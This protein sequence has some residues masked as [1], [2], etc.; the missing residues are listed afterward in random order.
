MKDA[1]RVVTEC[2][3]LQSRLGMLTPREES[4]ASG[5]IEFYE[6]KGYLSERQREGAM[7]LAVRVAA[8]RPHDRAGK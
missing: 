6:A 8:E 2:L 7:T 5:L 3:R 1:D 4:F